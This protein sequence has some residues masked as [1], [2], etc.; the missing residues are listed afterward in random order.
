[1]EDW[2]DQVNAG[3]WWVGDGAAEELM[4]ILWLPLVQQ[5]S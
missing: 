1:M 4:C 3:E 2:D 5:P